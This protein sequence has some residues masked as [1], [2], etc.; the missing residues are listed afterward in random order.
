[1]DQFVGSQAYITAA[2]IGH[3]C[4]PEIQP[5]GIKPTGRSLFTIAGTN[6][7]KMSS[8][9]Y[10]IET[11]WLMPK[12]P[13]GDRAAAIRARA[14]A[15]EDVPFIVWEGKV[16]ISADDAIR[17]TRTKPKPRSSEVDEFLH[18]VLKGGPASADDIYKEGKAKGFSQHQ[19]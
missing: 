11:Q 4:V 16:G 6:H 12:A 15:V 3:L 2:R 5:D 17:A 18:S 14:S 7:K 13:A 1:M 10:R 8:L 9:A 19:V